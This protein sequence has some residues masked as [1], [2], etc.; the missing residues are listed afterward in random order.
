MIKTYLATLFPVHR[1]SQGSWDSATDVN[2]NI[3][4][5]LLTLVR[6]FNR[7]NCYWAAQTVVDKVIHR[8]NGAATGTPRLIVT[9]PAVKMA[10][11]RTQP[12]SGQRTMW[13]P[14]IASA[15]LLH[16][17]SEEIS[18]PLCPPEFWWISGVRPSSG[19]TRKNKV[20]MRKRNCIFSPN[21]WLK[22]PYSTRV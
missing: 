17:S 18:C 3:D 15:I 7:S 11:T 14:N 8:P 21:S 16:R 9:P 19:I 13:I 20:A 12:I 6:N 5:I 10:R 22:K 1:K 4:R 2:K